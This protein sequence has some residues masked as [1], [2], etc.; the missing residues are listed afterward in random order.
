MNHLQTIERAEHTS[1]HYVAPQPQAGGWQAFAIAAYQQSQG[2]LALRVALTQRLRALTGQTLPLERIY[3]DPAERMASAT[4]DGVRFRWQHGQLHL[5]RG[6]THCGQG[7]LASPAL[8]S[9]A[10]LGYALSDWQ[11]HHP[12]CAAE[13]SA[14]WLE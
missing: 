12:A 6:C 5:L 3:T 13:D 7:A 10:D 1:W 8:H 4:L 14:G 2:D 9:P 11:P